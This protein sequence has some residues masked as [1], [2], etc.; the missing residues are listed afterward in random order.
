[1]QTT[2][3]II[4]GFIFLVVSIIHLMRV[5]IKAK[6]VV[7]DKIIIPIWVSM[8]AAPVTLLLAICMLITAR[9]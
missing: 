3:L 8:I 9:K 7:N 5:I 2:A 6:V 4:A 1:M